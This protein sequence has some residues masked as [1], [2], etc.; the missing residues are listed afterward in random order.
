M[1]PKERGQ[2][3]KRSE[4]ETSSQRLTRA[5]EGF[6]T[7]QDKV[8]HLEERVD[9]LTKQMVDLEARIHEEVE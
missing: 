9:R 2:K 7:L 5:L 8:E 6:E 3:M 4:E 1:E